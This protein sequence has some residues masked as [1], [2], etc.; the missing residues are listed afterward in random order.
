M[1]EK[2]YPPLVMPESVERQPVTLWSNGVALDADLYRPREMPS[3]A[4][5]VALT[6]GWGGSKATCERYAAAFAQ[7]GMVAL[8]FTHP[9][10]FGSGPKLHAT[11]VPPTAAGGEVVK[12]DVH[13][14]RNHIDPLDWLQNFQAAID[15]LEGEP[16][17]DPARLGAWGTSLGGGVAMHVAANDPRIKALAVQV[18][19]VGP[20]PGK[21]AVLARQRAI[22]LARG[23]VDSTGPRLDRIPGMSGTTN[24]AKWAHH[25]VRDQAEHLR[26]PTL[27]IDAGSEEMFKLDENC[28]RLHRVLAER[29]GAD[30][31]RYV[32]IP[33]IDHYGIYFDGFDTGCREAVDWFRAHL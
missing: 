3:A 21:G 30:K 5:A 11:G 19:I 15:Y 23:K 31:V 4:A 6:H 12:A 10:W 1:S 20:L 17:V 18:A 26:I 2:P 9:G 24:L 13:V 22:D 29:L 27:M 16:G 8:A 28:G 25:L 32:V 14:I 33:G 7:A